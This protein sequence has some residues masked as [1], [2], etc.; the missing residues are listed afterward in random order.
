MSIKVSPFAPENHPNMLPVMG[1]K[2]ASLKC[3]LKETGNKDLLLVHLNEGTTVAGVFTLSTTAAAPVDWC[4]EI[5]PNGKASALVVHSGNANAFTGTEGYKTVEEI[6]TI[7][8]E[9]IKC[10]KNQVYI[11]A[12][13]VIGRPVPKEKI[14]NFL[15]VAYSQLETNQWLSSAESIM[16]TDTFPKL[17]SHAFMFDGGEF[18]ISGFAKG[19]GM[20]MPNM[21][22]MLAFAFTDLPISTHYLQVLLKEVIDQTFNCIT[23]DSDTSTNDTFLLFSTNR[24]SLKSPITGTNDY[25]LDG[26]KHALFEVVKELALLVI[27][28]GEGISK[29]ITI[30]VEGADSADSA[31]I[32]AFSIA[33]SPLVKT[34]IAGGDPNWGRIIMAIGKSMEPVAKDKISVQIGKFCLALN[35]SPSDRKAIQGVDEYMQGKNVDIKVNVAVGSGKARVWTSDLTHEYISINADYTT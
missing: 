29:F 17:S 21:A 25:R 4:R 22:T 33:N 32:I 9:L 15:P 26:F 19:S 35:G 6:A 20:I 14:F 10:D 16:T 11:A 28:D 23:V 18:A 8:S 2:M 5:L 1:V 13:G 30:D 31:K 34:A 24:R 12:T 27:A 3:G 7:A